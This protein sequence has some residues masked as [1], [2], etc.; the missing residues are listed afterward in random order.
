LLS[1]WTVIC[2]SL[3]PVAHHKH[4]TSVIRSCFS[5]SAKF[6]PK[7]TTDIQNQYAHIKGGYYKSSLIFFDYLL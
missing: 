1:V 6:G 5:F 2:I 3:L 7:R 4:T